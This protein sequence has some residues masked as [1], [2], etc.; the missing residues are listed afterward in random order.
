MNTIIIVL[1]IVL[2]LIILGVIGYFI[3]KYSKSKL[4][5]PQN[6]ISNY[7]I[8]EIPIKGS[9]LLQRIFTRVSTVMNRIR[10][11]FV[12]SPGTV[13]SIQSMSPGILYS[14]G[15]INPGVS[16]T[17][18][19]SKNNGT[20]CTPYPTTVYFPSS[21]STISDPCSGYSGSSTRV[22]KDCYRK[23]W[24]DVG[25]GG[26]PFLIADKENWNSSQTLDRLRGDAQTW[27]RFAKVLKNPYHVQYCK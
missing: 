13:T 3:Y 22:S 8:G 9:D 26:D 7:N 20:N 5:C 1:I 23:L 18:T 14:R 17:I 6:D 2:V 4:P 11:K 24:A 27:Y 25:C 19:P 10:E 12:L 21:Q 16:S 15:T